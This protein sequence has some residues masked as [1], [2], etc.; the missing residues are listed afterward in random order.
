MRSMRKGS[1]A[2]RKPHCR[3]GGGEFREIY[4]LIL[5]ESGGE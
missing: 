1:V 3:G 4:T 5:L 2:E